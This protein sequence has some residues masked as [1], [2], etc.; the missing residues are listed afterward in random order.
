LRSTSPAR[1]AAA[2]TGV[3]ALA[4]PTAAGAAVTQQVHDNGGN[5]VPITPGLTIGNMQPRVTISAPPDDAAKYYTYAVTGPNGAAVAVDNACLKLQYGPIAR[6]VNYVGNGAYTM[7]T[8]LFSDADCKTPVDGGATGAFTIAAGAAVATPPTPLLTRDPGSYATKT[9]AFPTS[10]SPNGSQQILYRLYGVPDP[11]TG[12]SGATI[13]DTAYSSNGQ[14]QVSFRAP[15]R[16]TF[17]TRARAGS[18]EAYSPW[19]APQFVD[20]KAPFDL[21]TIRWTDSRGPSYRVRLQFRETAVNGPVRLRVRRTSGGRY[22]TVGRPKVHGGV[23]TKR[24]TLGR[25]GRYQL[26]VEYAGS[27][28]VA[29][30]SFTIGFRITRR[31]I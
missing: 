28:L 18:P 25:S 3:L 11:L 1:L 19:T 10:V 13:D 24:F 16:Y 7:T 30:G 17:V 23:V 2:I 9:Y 8:S 29:P 31:F 21:S 5:F 12:I 6:F 22:R 20:V 27:A 4:V 26:R 15:G 14:T